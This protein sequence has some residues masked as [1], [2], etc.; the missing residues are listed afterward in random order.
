MNKVDAEPWGNVRNEQLDRA[1]AVI[2]EKER[3]VEHWQKR[4]AKLLVQYQACM[5]VIRQIR[6]LA[7]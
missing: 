2:R 5:E 4:H 6:K 7:E 3:L 1:I